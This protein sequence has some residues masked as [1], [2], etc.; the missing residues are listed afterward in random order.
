MRT[1]TPA[2]A[3]FVTRQQRTEKSKKGQSD[4]PTTRNA[5]RSALTKVKASRW[6]YCSPKAHSYTGSKALQYKK[7]SERA[8]KIN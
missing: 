8:R 3:W 1:R 5:K 4:S 2:C 6:L 7:L